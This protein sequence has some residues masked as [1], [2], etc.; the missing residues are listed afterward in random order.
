MT[1]DQ[2]IASTSLRRPRSLVGG[3]HNA[4]RGATVTHYD[5]AADVYVAEW[6]GL[7]ALPPAQKTS[8]HLGEVRERGVA[9]GT[10]A[11]S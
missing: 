4:E 3:E 10:R 6:D 9:L 5:A 2:A 11:G 7:G 1:H 8:L